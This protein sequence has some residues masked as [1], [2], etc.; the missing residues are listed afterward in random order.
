MSRLYTRANATQRKI[1]RVIEG[2]CKNACDA[3]PGLVIS[4]RHRRS[5]AKRAAGTLTAI[6]PEVL[7]EGPSNAVPSERAS[8]GHRADPPEA[9]SQL[10]KAH[11][12][13]RTHPLSP[14]PL[15]ELRRRL[16][17]PLSAMKQAGEHERVAAF[18]EVL[19]IIAEISEGEEDNA[20]SA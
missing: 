19:K 7:A 2:A 4:P 14:S 1:L 15:V 6:W 18:V 3:H 11:Q 9:G 17:K 10:T 5:I 13:G 16:T 8:G 20:H 12:R